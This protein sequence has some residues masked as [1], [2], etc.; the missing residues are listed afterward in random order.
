TMVAHISH[1]IKNPLVSIGGFAQQLARQED[2]PEK[3][4]QKLKLIGQEVQRLEKFLADLS[5]YTRTAPTQKVSGDILA[6]IREV[7]A[8]MEAGFR[9]QGVIFEF[10]AP[11]AVPAF[12][13]DPGQIRQVLINLFKNSLEAMPQG[14]VLGVRAALREDDLV[15]TIADTGLGIAPEHLRSLFTPF[16]STKEGGTGLGLTICRGLIDLHRGEIAIR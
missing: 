12:A 10:S 16:F 1:E 15:L 7:I 4:R 2:F 9:E 6:L 5:T 11:E 3:G 13:F 8:F 14:G